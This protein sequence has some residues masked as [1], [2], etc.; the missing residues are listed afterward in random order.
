MNTSLEYRI[1]NS[2]FRH[3][4]YWASFCAGWFNPFMIAFEIMATC[5]LIATT[6]LPAFTVVGYA[7]GGMLL[8]LLGRYV[9]T[10]LARRTPTYSY[11]QGNYESRQA[12]IDRL[13][14]GDRHPFQVKELK[15]VLGI[16]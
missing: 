15:R 12:L 6:K 11:L 13:E 14:R 8:F 3:Y 16:K 10:W 4:V 9:C 5:A 2:N 7:V 1:I